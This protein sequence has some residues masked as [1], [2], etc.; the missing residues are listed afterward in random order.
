MRVAGVRKEHAAHNRWAGIADRTSICFY[1]VHTRVVANRIE[2]PENFAS[3][4][5]IGEQLAV[6]G[7]RK[8]DS[9]NRGDCRRVGWFA[10]FSFSARRIR[11]VPSRVSVAEQERRH[12]TTRIAARLIKEAVGRVNVFAI[13]CESP[14]N[15]ASAASL[16]SLLL[17]YRFPP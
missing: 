15:A 6:H 7:S 14:Q 3:L 4:R 9:R 11:S 8:H 2:F 17:P 12:T 5:R 10:G 1:A 16:S 13:H